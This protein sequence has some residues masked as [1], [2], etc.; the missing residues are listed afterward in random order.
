MYN[1]IPSAYKH[2]PLMDSIPHQISLVFARISYFIKDADRLR[3]E[4]L[5]EAF[6]NQN[7]RAISLINGLSSFL[8]GELNDDISTAWDTYFKNLLRK[9]NQHAIEP[10]SVIFT[11]ICEGLHTM[12]TL[13]K[14]ANTLNQIIIKTN[15]E[16]ESERPREGL[17]QTRKSIDTRHAIIPALHSETSIHKERDINISV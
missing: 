12:E 1:N 5:Y 15:D 13:W 9:L 17:T 2:N 16:I 10:N 7:Q 6:A 14:G 8:Q 3:N 4:H 11:S